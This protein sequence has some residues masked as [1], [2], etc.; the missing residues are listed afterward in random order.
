VFGSFPS[1]YKGGMRE[2]IELNG[3]KA[4][5]EEIERMDRVKERIRLSKIVMLGAR[6]LVHELN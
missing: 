3:K 5:K 4:T 6:L 2:N 1:H